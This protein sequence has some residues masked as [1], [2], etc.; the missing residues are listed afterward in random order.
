MWF[1]ARVMLTNLLKKANEL[2]AE[3]GWHLS[4]SLDVS[5]KFIHQENGPDYP[6]DVHSWF[7]CKNFANYS[8]DFSSQ[9]VPSAPPMGATS[10]E[11]NFNDTFLDLPPSYDQVMD[12]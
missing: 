1:E 2:G 11:W 7:F 8:E 5:A 6:I 9:S 4:T 12:S 3:L 10:L